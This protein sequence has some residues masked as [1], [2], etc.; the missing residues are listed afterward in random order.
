M[1][2]KFLRRTSNA[3]TKLGR[4]RKKKQVW[5]RPK[6]RDNKMRERRKGYPSVVSVGYRKNNKKR[7]N[8]ITVQNLNDLNN[9]RKSDLVN[10]GNVGKKKKIEMLNKANKEGIVF[11]NINSEKFLKK[12]EGEMKKKEEKKKDTK[13]SE[14]KES[15]GKGE[16]E[17]KS[18]ESGD[19]K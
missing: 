16:T 2:K 4:G 9:V 14:K 6:G 17:E 10:L 13:K 18:K 12:V 7:K 15:N 11:Q 8:V 5:R 1:G 3:Y 19:K